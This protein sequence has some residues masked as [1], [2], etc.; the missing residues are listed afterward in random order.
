MV[1]PHG[2]PRRDA[3]DLGGHHAR[4][5]RGHARP[6]HRGVAKGREM[7]APVQGDLD[8]GAHARCGRPGRARHLPLQVGARD[9]H[10]HHHQDRRH[11]G[12]RDD[13]GSGERPGEGRSREGDERR[14]GREALRGV[15]E[16][17]RRGAAHRPARALR[18]QGRGREAGGEA[19][20]QPRRRDGGEAPLRA[21][22]GGGRH[23]LQ[24][25]RPHRGSSGHPEGQR[26]AD[27]GRAHLRLRRE[28]LLAR[29]LL[30]EAGAA[31]RCRGRSSGRGGRSPLRWPA[32]RTAE[33]AVRDRR[34]GGRRSAHLP[35][36]ALRGGAE[37]GLSPCS[38]PR[39]PAPAP[40]AGRGPP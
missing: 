10:P 38:P 29:A 32:V 40:K 28:V 31:L 13:P 30:R 3:R 16:A 21:G 9:R 33:R 7:G 12:G 35:V 27:G 17:L 8:P 22:D 6:S 23:R 25:G 39:C 11:P 15:A 14:E 2:G 19:V 24:D 20:R 1:H 18:H 26:G 37:G 36:R 4:A 34:G 5:Q